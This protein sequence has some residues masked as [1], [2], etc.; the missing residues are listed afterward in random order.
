MICDGCEFKKDCDINGREKCM[1]YK[2]QTNFDRITASEEALAE[3]LHREVCT[4]CYQCNIDKCP[5]KGFD[6][7]EDWLEWLK[8]E[9]EERNE[10]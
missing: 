10:V 6:S 8:Q 7:Q 3:W 4:E 5:Y 2:P 1:D 9:S